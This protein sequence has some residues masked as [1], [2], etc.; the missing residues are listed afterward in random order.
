MPKLFTYNGSLD[1]ML[2]IAKYLGFKKI[3]LAGCDYLGSPP[4]SGHFYTYNDSKIISNNSNI[5]Y[6]KRILKLISD[7]EL[8]VEL[9]LPKEQKSKEIKYHNYETKYNYTQTYTENKYIVEQEVL[10]K[11]EKGEKKKQIFL[12]TD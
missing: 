10:K 8:N 3:L 4:L 12:W 11:M 2:G 5:N 7:L 9:I 6:K 1:F